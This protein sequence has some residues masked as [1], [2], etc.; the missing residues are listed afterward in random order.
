MK[1]Q[2]NKVYIVNAP[3]GVIIRNE[4]V[5]NSSRIGKLP[6]GKTI[7]L[8]E[9]TNI[10][11]Q[12]ID[13]GDTINGVWLK[14]KY[15]NFPFI[16]SESESEQEKWNLE[17]YVFS[18]YIEEL[19]KAN[20]KIKEL[21]SLQFFQLFINTKP[22]K[23]IKIESIEE[24]ERMLLNNVKWKVV[25]YLGRVIDE[26]RLENGQTLRINQK[27]NDMGFVAYYPLEKILLFEGGH[28]SDYSISLQTGESLET[29]GNP[30]YII[31]S[32]NR[33]LRLN[34]WFPGQ[35]CSSYFF[36]EK[37]GDGYRYLIDFGWGTLFGE[38]VCYFEKFCWI[39]DNEFVYSYM[40]YSGDNGIK[41]YYKGLIIIK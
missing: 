29:V 17:G 12:L 30:E 5:F 6:Y 25:D 28:S 21:D 31:E 41:K 15:N 18:E 10:K 34:G 40:D 22:Y 3:T 16:C 2:E 23:P 27:S 4:P 19:N 32:P 13:K 38:N 8:L 24:T 26:I 33:K 1:G 20:I 37:S 39:S 9:K 11:Q 7:E 35:E 14:I 36:Q